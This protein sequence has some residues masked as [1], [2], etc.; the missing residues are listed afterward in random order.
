MRTLV[1]RVC[2]GVGLVVLACA[3]V[4]AV[5]LWDLLRTHVSDESARIAHLLHRDLV[6]TRPM[7]IVNEEGTDTL[8]FG[9]DHQS[10]HEVV[11]KYSRA[12]ET[13][14]FTMVDALDDQTPF[15]ITSLRRI[16][17]ATSGYYHVVV[18]QIVAGDHSGE[19]FEVS[20]H[21]VLT[22][23]GPF[24]LLPSVTFAGAPTT[25]PSRPTEP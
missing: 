19:Q 3:M 4:Y 16:A 25:M 20:A 12:P 23:R 1:Y 15:K 10:V 14:S 8:W 7:L 2:V 13:W 6:T 21:E 22:E 18:I 17:K 9:R 11:E 5:W 24:T